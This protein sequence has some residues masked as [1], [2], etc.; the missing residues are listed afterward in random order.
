MLVSIWFV[1]IIYVW[2]PRPPAISLE[3]TQDKATTRGDG[4]WFLRWR[5]QC[6]VRWVFCWGAKGHGATTASQ[7]VGV[8][9]LNK[10]LK[11]GVDVI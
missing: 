3:R 6:V 8:V 10:Y 1:Y 11:P 9:A 5:S 2:A 7:A 4:A